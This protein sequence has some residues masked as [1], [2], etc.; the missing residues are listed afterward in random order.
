MKNN[1]LFDS[2][3]REIINEFYQMYPGGSYNNKP[4]VVTRFE[5]LKIRQEYQKEIDKIF[6]PVLDFLSRK[7]GY[8]YN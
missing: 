5:I 2:N 8:Y 6:K 1:L 3:E 4:L 7:L